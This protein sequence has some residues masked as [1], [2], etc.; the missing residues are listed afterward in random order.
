M[1]RTDLGTVEILLVED[2]PRDVDLTLRAIKRHH[3]AN[4]IHVARDGQE[5]LDYILGDASHEGAELA[6]RPK[7]VL[8]DLHLPKVDGIEVLRRLKADPK[9]RIIPVVVL[10]SSAREA[11][12]V[13]SYQLGVNSYIQKPVDFGEFI[14]CVAKMGFYW[15]LLN[16]APE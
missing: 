8:L 10:T 14:E 5:A 1:K 4:T 12:M 13:A 16:K 3:L 9:A 15:L 6:H 2:N 7:L 11:D